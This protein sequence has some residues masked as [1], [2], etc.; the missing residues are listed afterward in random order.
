MVLSLD[1]SRTNTYRVIQ[2]NFMSYNLER[3]YVNNDIDNQVNRKMMYPVFSFFSLT[4]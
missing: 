1:L 3:H 2:I 4:V